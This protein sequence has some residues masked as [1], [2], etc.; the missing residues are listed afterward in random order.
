VRP[1]RSAERTAAILIGAFLAALIS[2]LLLAPLIF[3][4]GCPG[5]A[6]QDSCRQY[7]PRTLLGHEA[8]IW[9]WGVTVVAIGLVTVW[10]IR[11]A[12]SHR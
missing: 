5:S 1:E 8:N 11:R 6:G 4:E 2:S 9:L 3:V 12:A 7:P 10:L